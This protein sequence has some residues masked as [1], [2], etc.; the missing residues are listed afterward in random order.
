M[1]YPAF[2]NR[3]CIKESPGCDCTPE[4]EWPGVEDITK[5][6]ECDECGES[7][8]RNR[9]CSGVST[10]LTLQISHVLI[11]LLLNQDPNK[12]RRWKGCNCVRTG[13]DPGCT[14]M[15]LQD[16]SGSV[17][18]NKKIADIFAPLP[19]FTADG[20]ANNPDETDVTW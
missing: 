14:L 9:K 10:S 2:E 6:L 20:L 3:T 17:E 4:E 18:E 13:E 15:A 16:P 1:P 8:N 11:Y 19:K 5:I 12:N 7:L